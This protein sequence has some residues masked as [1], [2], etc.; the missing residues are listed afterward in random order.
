MSYKAG[1]LNAYDWRNRGDRAIIEAQMAW[2]RSKIPDVE[3]KVFSPFWMENQTAFG[4]EAS[5]LPPIA[6]DRN[7]KLGGGIIHPI[8]AW[9]RAIKG[10]GRGK[11]WEEFAACDG[12]FLCGGGY[13]Y[14]SHSPII[15]RQLWLHVANSLL[16]LRS[17]K[18]VM[19]FPQSWGPFRKW[20]D[21]W[22]CWKLASELP[23]VSARGKISAQTVGDM[24]FA[25]KTRNLPDVVLAMRTLRP[26]LFPDVPEESRS[27]LGIAPIEFGFARNCTEEDRVEYLAK[28]EQ[29]AVRF[30]RE[31]HQPITLFVQVSVEGH[32]D[33]APM[34]ERLA[35][36]LTNL[37]I[38]V[39]IENS[40]DY[41]DYWRK[42]GN[43]S[44]FIGCRMHSCI[45]SMVTGVPTIGLAYQPKFVELFDELG[46]KDRCFDISHFEVESVAHELFKSDFFG[47]ASSEKVAQSVAASA[48]RM[49]R[50]FD[51]CWRAGGFPTAENDDHSDTN[52]DREL[53]LSYRNK[54]FS[55][56][57][58]TPT[59]HQL[60]ILKQCAASVA[61]QEGD[62]SV[63]HLIHDAGTGIEFNDWASSQK[64]AKCISEPDDGMYDAINR[65]FKRATGDVVA[66]LNSDEQYLP[67]TLQLVA[68]YFQQHPEVD[69]L[70][71]DVILVDQALRPLA[72]R[73]AVPPTIGHIR[74]SHLSTFS[75]A[76]FVRRKVLDDGHF[77]DTRWK[78]I[79]DAVWIDRLLNKGYRVATLDRPLST[80][81]MLGSNLGQSTRLDFER[82]EW[83]KEIGATS[84]LRKRFYIYQYRIHKLFSGAYSPKKP[85]VAAYGPDLASRSR[86]SRLLWGFWNGA[87]NEVEVQ[88]VDHEGSFFLRPGKRYLSRSQVGAY[89][90]VAV[91]LALTSDFIKSGES[92][93][94][95]MVLLFA[96]LLLALRTKPQYLVIASILFALVSAYAMR[97]RPTDV[98][99][100]RMVSVIITSILAVLLSYSLRSAQDWMMVATALIRKIP[101]PV[102][103]TDCRGCIVLVNSET[104]R[105]L[106]V[107]ELELL[108][109]NL[110]CWLRADSQGNR[111]ETDI[112]QWQDRLPTQS[113]VIDF[114]SN[115]PL[116][117]VTLSANVFMVGSG[118]KRLFGFS[119]VDG[120]TVVHDG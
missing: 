66:W 24:G 78:T 56:S 21:R 119:L 90:L 38:P 15:S 118:K 2:I 84:P 104:E 10:K 7:S 89:V 71:G 32:D 28:L 88:R 108:Q 72:Y 3:F 12:Y 6:A 45:F 55:I 17:G 103:L 77:L 48:E 106:S 35:S 63:E 57:V 91:I 120:P 50:D 93:K 53:P 110:S 76:T 62:F 60:A 37:G 83:E 43:Q 26:D 98:I 34:A 61:D 42:I 116:E 64:F 109:E 67:R 92:V 96:L 41:A 29:I 70:I 5:F 4:E 13:L 107:T 14:S 65:G 115:K 30:Y 94:A 101:R 58:V 105:L 33:D 25:S 75:A 9:M 97:M 47:R 20:A 52:A 85:T 51:D 87:R 23:R 68:K 49:L 80:F 54:K 69:I 74:H 99:I 95:P 44:G 86:E 102:V 11:A 81:A 112:S 114:F 31:R 27:G 19:Q 46:L 8:A 16:A 111:I 59:Y 1:I 73:R 79:A 36:L 40:P 117:T 39:H 100:V 82:Q 22:V 113:L 18:P